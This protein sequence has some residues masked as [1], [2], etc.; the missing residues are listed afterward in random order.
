MTMGGQDDRV[1]RRVGTPGLHSALSAGD[2]REIQAT[3]QRAG[4]VFVQTRI[5]G[6]SGIC[7]SVFD[8]DRA[9]VDRIFDVKRL[10][11]TADHSTLRVEQI[12]SCFGCIR[13][14]QL[15]S[16]F[17]RELRDRFS[18][19]ADL[20]SEADGLLI[21]AGAGMGVDAGLP[22]FRGQ[23]GFWKAYPALAKS[24]IRF[25][26]IASPETFESDPGLAWGFYGHRLAL[27]R[28]TQPHEGYRILLKWSRELPE[29][30][31][32]FTSNVDGMFQKAGLPNNRV[33]ECHG[34]IHHL[35]CTKPC[36]AMIWTAGEVAPEVDIDRCCLVSQLPACP[37]C[38][39]VARPNILMFG[40][41]DWLE[42]RTR[43][44]R[45]R[46]D[47]WLG[48]V[49]RPLVLELGAGTNIPTVRRFGEDVGAPMIRINPT[50]SALGRGV[51]LAMGALDALRGIDAAVTE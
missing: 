30:V 34:S 38:S 46:L 45:S 26:D 47:R 6:K 1:R 41:P 27:Y 35:Q 3:R 7:I 49:K 21:T 50:D 44:Q 22:D 16:E 5:P 48:G 23:Q 42:H 28:R 31:F 13:G 15:S 12:A 4:R 11:R 51:S 37:D 24:G 14:A 32:V 39:S 8:G 2:D 36:L 25:Q 29:G 17:S 18:R 9:G 10:D 40:D 19:C 43:A 20:I 33:C